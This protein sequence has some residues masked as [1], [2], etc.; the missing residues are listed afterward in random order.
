MD[1]RWLSPVIARETQLA[2]SL[3]GIK[4]LLSRRLWVS[5]D[6]SSSINHGHRPRLKRTRVESL[7]ETEGQ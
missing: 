5:Y 6:V 7:E 1:P 3:E 4:D 2:V